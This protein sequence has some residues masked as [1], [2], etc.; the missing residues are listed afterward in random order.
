[1]VPAAWCPV[2]QHHKVA[3]N[4]PWVHTELVPQ[5]WSTT[6]YVNERLVSS[7]GTTIVTVL[8]PVLF[9][10]RAPSSDTNYPCIHIGTTY[11]ITYWSSYSSSNRH[12][13]SAHCDNKKSHL[14]FPT[15]H[16]WHNSEVIQLWVSSPMYTQPSLKCQPDEIAKWVEHPSPILGDLG[17]RTHEF[18]P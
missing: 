5:L 17:I 10:K 15:Q 4:A 18:E 12:L 3:M 14:F 9:L 11:T 13:V 1:M 2:G 6:S 8:R 16:S 7:S